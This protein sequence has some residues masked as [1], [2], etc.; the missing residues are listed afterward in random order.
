MESPSDPEVSPKWCLI[1][2]VLQRLHID[3]RNALLLTI[4]LLKS[5]GLRPTLPGHCGLLT[6]SFLMVLGGVP[7][8]ADLT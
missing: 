2:A 3:T 5:A 1:A 8:D 4:Q 7:A 6:P